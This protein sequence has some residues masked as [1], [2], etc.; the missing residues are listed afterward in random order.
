VPPNIKVFPTIMP[1]V[2]LEEWEKEMKY[3]L[4]VDGLPKG[5]EV[6]MYDYI[7]WSTAPVNTERSGAYLAAVQT[8]TIDTHKNCICAFMGYCKL[9]L[10]VPKE[11]LG[12]HLYAEPSKVMDFLAFLKARG[13]GKGHLTK[14][15]GVARKVNSFLKAG[16]PS[17]S[18]A[19]G[20]AA[21]M[22]EWLSI[23]ETQ[24]SLSIPNSRVPQLP[25][26]GN[27]RSWV[28]FHVQA[29]LQAVDHELKSGNVSLKT[30]RM[31]SVAST[32][33]TLV[34]G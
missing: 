15:C 31:V 1:S 22:D 11:G 26:H 21:K 12:M 34:G 4:S 8:S 33:T 5:L 6:E 28:I 13:V 30:M 7:F 27:V 32:H 25:D 23:L 29:A 17:D 24:L 9:V 14:H 16:T 18:K 20:H 19:R 10:G 2:E 3:G